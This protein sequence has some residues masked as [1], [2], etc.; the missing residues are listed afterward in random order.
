MPE[1]VLY[2]AGEY[3]VCVV[4]INDELT[5][6][7]K[8]TYAIRHVPTDVIA[9]YG[10]QLSG[11]MTAAEDLDTALVQKRGQIRARSKVMQ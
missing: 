7:K 10:Q 1:Q 8:R 6:G 2:T 3:E 4:E 9:G 11:M 5:G